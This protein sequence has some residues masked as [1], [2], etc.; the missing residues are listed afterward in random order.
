MGAALISI[1]PYWWLLSEGWSR[2]R[3]S[4]GKVR[5]LGGPVKSLTLEQ[6][7]AGT[8]SAAA[9]RGKS[10]TP[11]AA[12]ALMKATGEGVEQDTELDQVQWEAK[13]THLGGRNVLPQND[14]RSGNCAE[15]CG[16][17]GSGCLR[18]S[19]GS[20]QAAREKGARAADNESRLDA[21][22]SSLAR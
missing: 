4:R 8:Q 14:S 20:V 2:R 19:A 21:F 9:Q 18:R 6:Q 7:L 22:N 12:L 5:G 13:G 3:G 1:C 10:Q 17:C 16:Q 11:A 15:E